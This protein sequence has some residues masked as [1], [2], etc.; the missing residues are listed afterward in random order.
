[1]SC[2]AKDINK[3]KINYLI[4]NLKAKKYIVYDKPYQLNIVGIRNKNTDSSKFDD[5]MFVFWKDN[6]KKWKGREYSITTDPSTHYLKKGGL[7]TYKGNLATAILPMG[8]YVNTF[9]LGLHKGQYT[10]LVQSKNLCVYR[11]YDRNAILSFD[12]EDKTCGMFGI[13]MHR[14]NKTGTTK[15]IGLYSAGCQVFANA[16]CYNE[17]ISLAKKQESLYGNAFTYTLIDKWLQNQFNIKRSLFLGSVIL[18]VS[19]LGYGLYLSIKEK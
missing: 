19:V 17:F 2:K 7:G 12:I 10:A 8:Q 15:E 3:V 4:A 5:Q 13:N 1:M 6:D 18:G 11:D 16:E 9:K 14:A